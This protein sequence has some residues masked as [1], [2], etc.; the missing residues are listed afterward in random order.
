[1][2]L[3]D[4]LGSGRGDRAL[5]AAGVAA[6]VA[7]AVI[8]NALSLDHHHRW[9]VTRG[10]VHT[11]SPATLAT[12]R[13]LREPVDVWVL[14]AASEPLS[15]SVRHTLE[16]YQAASARIVRH[17]VD[18]DK[19]PAAFEDVRRRFRLESGR[20]ED[21]RV[22][23]NVAVVV[24]RGD[25][26]W[27]VERSDL[28]SIDSAA[29]A[30]VRPR[31]ERALTHA[32]RSVL[33]GEKARLCFTSGHDEPSL[34]DAGPRGAGA[35]AEVLRKDNYEAVSV[36]L[37]GPDVSDPFAGCA[38]LVVATPRRAFAEADVTRLRTFLL[39]GGSALFALSPVVT[40]DGFVQ[41]GL[42]PVLASF[43]VVPADALVVEPDPH[44]AFPE[45]RGTQLVA[46][47]RVHPTTAALADEA[48]SPPP[49]VLSLV[50][51]LRRGVE[52]P[53][54]PVDLLVTSATAFG[55]TRVTEDTAWVETPT[56][57]EGDLPG[58]L[59]LAMASE[60]PKVEAGAA[61]GPRIVVVGTS[62]VLGRAELDPLAI[63][64]TF[65]VE[66]A[67]SWLVSRPLVL[68]IP[69]R[70]PVIAALR[71]T[72]ASRAEVKRYV[73]GAIPLTFAILGVIVGVVRRRSLPPGRR[74][75]R[76]R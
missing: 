66:G 33:S 52:S 22:A 43:G 37:G 50:R 47:V 34:S 19:D 21:G 9:D 70:P 20:A 36:A 28:V 16:A 65:F 75:R 42:A 14:L 39:G 25:R 1:M 3:K 8:V 53:A 2:G 76:T 48:S 26:H 61:R 63:G 4:R 73:L 6:A 45:A 60:R 74:P 11:L 40:R 67:I 56:R 7:F 15:E 69:D 31:E 59:V 68:D 54:A 27:F 13:D 17:V 49:V 57:G 71:L 64:G 29:D 10:A 51:P 55:A 32:I 23:E 30:R 38:A 46:D 5:G 35:L 72:E 62:S 41:D 12:L 44:R 18:P 58:P 24:A